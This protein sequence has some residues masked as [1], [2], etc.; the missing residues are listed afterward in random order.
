MR[1]PLVDLKTQYQGIK[2]EVMAEIGQAL[3][4]MQLFLGK[5]VQAVESNFASF[6]G[7]E[8]AIGVGSGTDA[9]H[10]AIRA[11]GIGPGDEVVTV[12]H[13]FIATVEAIVLAGARPVLVDIDPVTCNMDPAQVEKAIT[14][15]TRAIIPVHLYGHPA[16]MDPIL[17]LAGA[18]RLKVIE[19][20]CQ[21]HGAEYR[22]RRTG[23]LGDIGC[24][25]FYFTKN[26]GG[27]GEGGII[28]TSDP[29]IAKT[30]R[31]IRDHGQNAKYYHAVMAINGRLDEV[32]AAVLKVK[33]AYLDKWTEMRRDIASA[34]S[35]RLPS[36]IIKPREMP[37][38]KHVYHL[39]VV[40]TPERD[41]LKEWLESKG[42]STGMH[43]PVPVHMQEAWR[44][45][46]GAE[47]SLPVTEKTVKEILSLPIY[48][49]LT[50]SE[51]GYICDSII[52]FSESRI[53]LPIK[54]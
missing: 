47:C 32:Q 39:Y 1:I 22:G 24:F 23:S 51:V 52:E 44:R 9:L 28:T 49:E 35:A 14:S 21:A 13:T 48:P 2:E 5:N 10:I 40:R 38:G 54:R 41:Q 8:F 19:D 30:C 15:R 7:T 4:G 43:Y 29:D 36:S 42:V 16:D 17:D 50:E 6:C 11:L 37:W 31:M 33:L 3:D 27:Y 45:Y 12:A 46:G 25:S 20:A 53:G 34:Y 26:L 18:Y